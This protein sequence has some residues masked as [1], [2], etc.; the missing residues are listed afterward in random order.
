MMGFTINRMVL[1]LGFTL[2]G[3]LPVPAQESTADSW[4]DARKAFD[5]AEEAI[6]AANQEAIQAQQ[7]A[8]RE[9]QAAARQAQYSDYLRDVFR[10]ASRDGFPPV[11][12]FS[13]EGRESIDALSEDLKIMSVVLKRGLKKE[14]SRSGRVRSGISLFVRDSTS[15]PV[16]GMYLEGFGALFLFS[17]DFPLL[18]P[19]AVKKGEEVARESSEWERAREEI[20]GPRGSYS[21]P[22]AAETDYNSQR[23]EALKIKILEIL[24]N[25]SHIRNLKPGDVVSVVVYGAAF[26]YP[27]RSTRGGG[28]KGGPQS[29]AKPSQ[30]NEM[31]YPGEMGLFAPRVQRIGNGT[32]LA[33]RAKKGDIDAFAS[34]E[35]K[36]EQLREKAD[37]AAYV[38]NSPGFIQRFFAPSFSPGAASR[39][40]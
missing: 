27:V 39:T 34:G 22:E 19:P 18:P 31:A 8:A 9:A 11:V 16:Q 38:G 36:I 10:L 21:V 13:E 2:S 12:F 4:Q 20:F 23:V 3:L 15:P 25:A 17:V 14:L 7:V 28:R 33:I 26:S 37:I 30:S 32:V 6:R 35:L 24:R 40:P 1:A 5:Q 29:G